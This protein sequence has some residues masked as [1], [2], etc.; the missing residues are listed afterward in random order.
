M[1]DDCFESHRSFFRDDVPGDEDGDLLSDD[2]GKVH[3]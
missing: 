1:Y 3:Q 2:V